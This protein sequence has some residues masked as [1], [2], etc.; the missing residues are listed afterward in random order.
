[1]KLNLSLW[2]ALSLAIGSVALVIVIE[3]FFPDNEGLSFISGFLIAFS[4]ILFIKNVIQR[5]K[6]TSNK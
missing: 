2:S 3:R 1:M 6:K 4:M 5:P